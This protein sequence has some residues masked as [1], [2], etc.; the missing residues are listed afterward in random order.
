MVDRMF[1]W[2]NTP[3]DIRAGQTRQFLN[4][5]N[6]AEMDYGPVTNIAPRRDQIVL[7][8]NL[9]G[10]CG[11]RVARLTAEEENVALMIDLSKAAMRAYVD[12]NIP[13]VAAELVQAFQAV[14]R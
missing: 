9:A 6:E 11:M 13:K 8:D 4:W 7:E 14:R 2:S 12:A 5:F 10:K 1:D 3:S